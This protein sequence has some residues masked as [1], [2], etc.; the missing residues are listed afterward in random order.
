MWMSIDKRVIICLENNFHMS[1]L[2]YTADE[3]WERDKHMKERQQRL[4]GVK[5]LG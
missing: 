5:I 2:L 3:R 1:R 4:I